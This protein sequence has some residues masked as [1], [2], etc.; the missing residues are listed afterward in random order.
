[1]TRIVLFTRAWRE[2]GSREVTTRGFTRE[3]AGM[4][5]LF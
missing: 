5:R 2:R 3:E 1:M 4:A